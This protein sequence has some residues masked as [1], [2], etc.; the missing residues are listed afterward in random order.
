[1]QA[2]FDFGAQAIMREVG[3]RLAAHFGPPVRPP[4][5]PAMGQ[6]VRS[7]ISGKT[8]DAV[9]LAAYE[10]LTAAF[11]DWAEMAA[12]TPEDIQRLI[13]PVKHAER[14]A[15]HLLAALRII[16]AERPGFDLEFLRG[17]PVDEAHAWLQRLPGVGPKVAASALN[18]STL[19]QP[20]FV[21]DSHVVRVLRRLR[22]AGQKASTAA[23]YETVM[24]ATPGW[25]AAALADL[26]VEMKRLS[27]TT[28]RHAAADCGHCPLEPLCP[29][30]PA[31]AR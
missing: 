26:H 25:S 5:R 14:K 27:Q 22:L 4:A 15:V 6:L 7:L 3:E 12:A 9:S 13:Q 11:A 8:Y 17:L 10:R 24:A 19:E 30:H 31:E 2:R 20:A 1:M 29:G 21:V 18:F 23:M 28:C 16:A